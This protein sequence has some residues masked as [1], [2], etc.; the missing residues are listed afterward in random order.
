VQARAGGSAALNK[1][2]AKGLADDLSRPQQVEF[3]LGCAEC[4]YQQ[5]RC[6][7]DWDFLCCCRLHSTMLLCRVDPAA[8]A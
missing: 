5:V 2:Q 8:E 3:M 7:F 4:D 6:V 1:R